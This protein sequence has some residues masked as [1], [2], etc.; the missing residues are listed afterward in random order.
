MAMFLKKWIAW[1]W[2][3]KSLWKKSAGRD[4]EQRQ[5]Q[6][7]RARLES[8]STSKAASNLHRQRD[9]IGQARRW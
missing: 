5:Q 3:V 9:G 1:F 2:S 7:H 6:G 8:A 4:G